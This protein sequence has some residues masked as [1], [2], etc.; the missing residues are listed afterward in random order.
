MLPP[1]AR[2]AL[3]TSA[4]AARHT[5]ALDGCPSTT[6]CTRP[7]S[8]GRARRQMRMRLDHAAPSA[9]H[10]TDPDSTATSTEPR[11]GS[12]PKPTPI[13]CSRV[14]PSEG[15]PRSS[16]SEARWI[17]GAAKSITMVA[18]RCSLAAADAAGDSVAR[19]MTLSAWP[20]PVPGGDSI[21]NVLA[22]SPPCSTSRSTP[23]S[24]TCTHPIGPSAAPLSVNRPP[25]PT[26]SS[27]G[28]TAAIRGVSCVMVKLRDDDGLRWSRIDTVSGSSR[29]PPGGVTHSMTSCASTTSQSRASSSAPAAP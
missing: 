7:D 8:S 18:E 10:A 20:L 4:L 14:P 6:A 1:S 19:W 5:Y 2:E 16:T 15:L 9:S 27:R 24:S 13:I 26:S 28:V 17:D 22:L 21:T 29:P 23:S 11:V 12:A 3:C 25:P